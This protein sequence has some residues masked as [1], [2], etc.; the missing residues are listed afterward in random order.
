MYNQRGYVD[1]VSKLA[2]SS[3]VQAVENVKAAP[4]Y[5]SNGEASSL[6]N[7]GA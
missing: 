5:A 7:L 1:L 3:M 4:D 2:G 6:L